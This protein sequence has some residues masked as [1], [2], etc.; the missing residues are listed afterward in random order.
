MIH[1]S[2]ANAG[3]RSTVLYDKGLNPRELFPCHSSPG[4]E[5]GREDPSRRDYQRALRGPDLRHPGR[6]SHAPPHPEDDAG[7][8]DAAE[9][10]TFIKKR[11][12]TTS[13]KK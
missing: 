5:R 13:I 12:Y 6:I 8:W 3:K 7:I 4:R 10:I 2:R 11:K 9:G 1:I